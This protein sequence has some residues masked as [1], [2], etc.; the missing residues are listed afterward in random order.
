MPVVFGNGTIQ[1]AASLSGS[2]TTYG[3]VQT[4]AG[5]ITQPKVPAGGFQLSGTLQ[6]GGGGLQN[7]ANLSSVNL[8]LQTSPGRI[9][10]P[11]A[12]KYYISSRQVMAS[13][14]INYMNIRKNGFATATGYMDNDT[15]YDQWVETIVDMA[16]NDYIEIL[17]DGSPAGT[18]SRS[19]ATWNSTTAHL[20]VYK[21]A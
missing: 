10:V 14:D 3:I 6:T 18:G 13:A 4:A 17:Y 5:A 16:A 1:G 12:G 8:T 9:T 19:I 2:G 7:F 20:C 15:Y 21:V 11:V